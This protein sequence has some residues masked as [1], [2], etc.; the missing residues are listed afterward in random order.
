M[1]ILI[2][3]GWG[4]GWGSYEGIKYAID[5]NLI[6]FVE[7]NKDWQQIARR[8]ENI[9]SDYQQEEKYE[10][11]IPLLYQ[12]LK[13]FLKN[14]FY[15]KEFELLEIFENIDKN[16]IPYISAFCECEIYKITKDSYYRINEEEGAENL[17]ILDLSKWYKA[18]D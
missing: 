6:N 17:E 10:F 5:K 13:C 3:H 9:L 1:K 18:I 12:D 2:S 4:A 15:D 8:L 7:K 16:K 11:N 14:N